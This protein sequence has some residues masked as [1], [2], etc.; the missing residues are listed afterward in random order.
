MSRLFYIKVD[1][2]GQPADW[3]FHALHELM[4]REGFRRKERQLIATGTLSE[5]SY[6]GMREATEDSL[7][8]SL[9]RGI[10]E[11][12]WGNNRVSV[13]PLSA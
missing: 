12:V 13:S 8:E 5:T 3:Q 10:A 11:A 4:H 6:F 9:C 2:H 1:L 7:R